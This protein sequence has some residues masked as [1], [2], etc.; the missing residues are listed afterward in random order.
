MFPP[1]K[2]KLEKKFDNLKKP[3]EIYEIYIK[4]L[5]GF[6]IEEDEDLNYNFILMNYKKELYKSIEVFPDCVIT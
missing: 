2:T 6:E 5:L 1:Q 3:L 4:A